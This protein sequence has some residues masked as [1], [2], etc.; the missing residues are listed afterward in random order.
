[1]LLTDVPWLKRGEAESSSLA[2]SLIIVQVSQDWSRLGRVYTRRSHYHRRRSGLLLLFFVLMRWGM[3]DGDI[4]CNLKKMEDKKCI[5]RW[6]LEEY[7]ERMNVG[8]VGA[9]NK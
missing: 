2:G 8:Y 7:D 9:V 4:V 3:D 6:W 5:V 1:M